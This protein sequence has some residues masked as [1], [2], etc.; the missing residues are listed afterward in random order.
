MR[1][2][3]LTQDLSLYGIGTQEMTIGDLIYI[4]YGC[5]VPVILRRIEGSDEYK[6]VGECY[7]HNMMD[8]QALS[9]CKADR[10]LEVMVT[11]V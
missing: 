9:L 11:L 1:R 4:L 7:V 2:L 3:F 6:L 8:G 10:R 5:S